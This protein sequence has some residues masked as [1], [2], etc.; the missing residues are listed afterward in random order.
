MDRRR[1]IAIA[2]VLATALA[3]TAATAQAAPN[4]NAQPFAVGAPGVGDDYAFFEAWLFGRTRPP[5]PGN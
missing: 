5:L 1:I 4:P 2:A 3:T